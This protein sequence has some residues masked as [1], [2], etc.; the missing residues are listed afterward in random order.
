MTINLTNFTGMQDISGRVT[1]SGQGDQK[2]TSTSGK[3][4]SW[5]KSVFRPGTFAKE[6]QKAMRAFV[7]SITD[8]YGPGMGR[9][10][11]RHLQTDLDA[12][13]ALTGARIRNTIQ[14]VKQAQ[15]QRN[16]EM[17]NATIKR[18]THL[19]PSDPHTVLGKIITDVAGSMN[20]SDRIDE[21]STD[22]LR[23]GIRTALTEATKENKECLSQEKARQITQ[24]VVKQQLQNILNIDR[25]MSKANDLGIPEE[26]PKRTAL[27]RYLKT[28]H[29]PSTDGDRVDRLVG[30][31]KEL[32]VKANTDLKVLNDLLS[33]SDSFFEKLGGENPGAHVVLGQTTRLIGQIGKVAEALATED[34]GVDDLINTL[35][36]MFKVDVASGKV[37]PTRVQ[38]CFN[39]LTSEVGKQL[40]GTGLLTYDPETAEKMGKEQT[41]TLARIATL[42]TSLIHHLGR[43]LDKPE[44]DLNDLTGGIPLPELKDVD[45][46]VLHALRT[47][48]VELPLSSK[49]LK[50]ELSTGFK[51]EF[52]A[53]IPG[54]AMGR[55]YDANGMDDQCL[56]DMNRG[57]YRLDGQDITRP[58]GK[59]KYSVDRGVKALMK[60][61]PNANVRKMVS[62]L[63]HQGLM[64]NFLNTQLLR[65]DSPFQALI[66]EKHGEGHEMIYDIRTDDPD[67][68]FIDF[69]YKTRFDRM[70]NDCGD[71]PV[72]PDSHYDLKFTVALDRHLAEQGIPQVR[73]DGPMTYDIEIKK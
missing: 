54:M 31:V 67:T 5:F 47:V 63:A 65:E 38:N 72:R 20:M 57:V 64:A 37:S 53:L 19:N 52:G 1:I 58:G 46:N 68:I 41:V 73:V 44:G 55:Q 42:G 39:R 21:L 59:G 36:A 7:Q 56:K 2:Q 10:A 29:I 69:S 17:N 14:Q 23:A 25:A 26:S 48:G 34:M 71:M 6:N 40:I 61:L 18:M 32:K 35:K 24:R 12:G 27:T 70:I 28:H 13:L 60:K 66:A 50:G 49:T 4:A 43:A 22:L 51:Q 3:I 45:V 8:K 11:T 30:L 15:I 9:V 62:S 16:G 33:H